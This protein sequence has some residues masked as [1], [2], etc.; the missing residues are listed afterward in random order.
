MDILPG[1]ASSVVFVGL[2][3]LDEDRGRAVEILENA[4][5]FRVGLSVDLK[6]APRAVVREHAG[7]VLIV[8]HRGLVRLAPDFSATPVL[9]AHWGLLYPDTAALD[10]AGTVYVGMRGVVGKLTPQADGYREEWLFP[11]IGK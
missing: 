4:T 3:H 6:S 2:A 11:P 9:D 7:T 8:T 5:R 10:A 1:V